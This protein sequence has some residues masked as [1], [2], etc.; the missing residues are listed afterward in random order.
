MQTKAGEDVSISK[1]K[2]KIK[3]IINNENKEKPYSDQQIADIMNN[4]GI[5][6]SRR[7]VAK[8]REEMNIPSSSKRKYYMK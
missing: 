8:Y 6:I 5:N 3:E 2:D 7:T 1:L 4:E